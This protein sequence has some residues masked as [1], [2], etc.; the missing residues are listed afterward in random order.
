MAEL[1]DIREQI[2]KNNDPKRIVIKLNTERLDS[3][4]YRASASEVISEVFPNWELDDRVR[5][6]A[7]AV[8]S[9]Q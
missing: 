2:F 4:E 5:F 9:D 6:L 7:V 8:W 1:S 3:Q